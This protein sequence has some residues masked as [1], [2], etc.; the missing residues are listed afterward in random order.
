MAESS[1]AKSETD[2]VNKNS[3]NAMPPS[4]N[5]LHLELDDIVGG[6]EEL[7]GDGYTS[8]RT[9]SS[10]VKDDVLEKPPQPYIH[11]SSAPLIDFLALAQANAHKAN[12][13]PPS[14]Q[15]QFTSSS[16]HTYPPPSHSTPHNTG[17]EDEFVTEP[18]LEQLLTPEEHRRGQLQSPHGSSGA[19]SESGKH[20]P[21]PTHSDTPVTRTLDSSTPSS[22]V[23]IAVPSHGTTSP[24]PSSSQG[25]SGVSPYVMVKEGMVEASQYESPGLLY[26][27]SLKEKHNLDIL[28]PADEVQYMY[29]CIAH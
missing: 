6:R 19:S 29:K 12:S 3:F 13:K 7:D 24:R 22:T 18:S 1:E 10:S 11:A 21:N 23:P 25:L 15:V 9:I 26:A 17:H 28:R 2:P 20:T 4:G 14:F 8:D 16:G 27:R 5:T